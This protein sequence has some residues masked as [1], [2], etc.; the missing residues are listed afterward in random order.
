[1]ATMDISACFDSILQDK[2]LQLL[3]RLL[4]IQEFGV[5]NV[6][7]VQL[8]LI[9][10]NPKRIP[11][12]SARPIQAASETASGKNMACV[13]VDKVVCKFIE[14]Q[15][16]FETIKR[17]LLNNVIMVSFMMALCVCLFCRLMVALTGKSTVFLKDP[18]Y[19]QSSVAYF[20]ACLTENAILLAI[21]KIPLLCDI[22]MTLSLLV[23]TVKK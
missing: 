21:S 18:S 16:V 17:H 9:T 4:S 12:R 19:L 1:M 10:G 15:D 5:K 8:D 2:L 11:S 14:G 20:T 7:I 13:V 6:D 3:E 22:S 23:P